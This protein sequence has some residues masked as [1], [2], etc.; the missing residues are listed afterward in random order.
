MTENKGNRKFI[1]EK[2]FTKEFFPNSPDIQSKFPDNA[3]IF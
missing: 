1:T 2:Y 3:M